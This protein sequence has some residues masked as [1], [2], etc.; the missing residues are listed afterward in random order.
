MILLDNVTYL[1]KQFPKVWEQIRHFQ[2][3]PA[4]SVHLELSKAGDLTFKIQSAGSYQYLHSKYNPI[5]EAEL[6][7]SKYTDIE[8]YKQIFF[9][10]IGLGY[11]I[12]SFVERYPNK[13]YS[14]YEP[15]AEILSVY[16]SQKS[17]EEL[18]FSNIIVEDTHKNI[19]QEIQN[20]V[21]LINEDVLIVTLPSYERI[22]K[23]RFENFSTTLKNAVNGRRSAMHVNNAFEKRWILNS[24]INIQTTLKTPD[25]L[26]MKKDAFNGK[27]AILVAAGPSLEDEINN[28]KKIKEDGSAYIFSVGASIN[29]F[30]K[31]EFE[32]D[33][34]LTYDPTPMNQTVFKSVVD[35]K[36]DTIPLIYGTTVGFE[37]LHSYPGPKLH[38]VTSQDAIADFFFKP[39]DGRIL[40]LV[41]DAPSISVIALQFMLKLGF[42]PI[43]LVGQN[44]AYRNDKVYSSSIEM[45]ESWKITEEQAAFLPKVEDV[46]GQTTVTTESY[47]QMKRSMEHILNSVKGTLFLNTT[48]GGARIEGTTFVHLDEVMEQYLNQSV[49]EKD[50][51]KSEEND[52]Y[53]RDYLTVQSEVLKKHYDNIIVVFQQLVSL[54]Q[55]MDYQ[56]K[57]NAFKNTDKLFGKFD[58]QFRTL[59]KNHYYNYILAPMNRVRSDLLLKQ[60]GR[61]KFE[62]DV[63]IKMQLIINE[64][65]KYMYELQQDMKSLEPVYFGLNQAIAG[66]TVNLVFN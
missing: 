56:I 65:G 9:Y 40:D 27:P 55:E 8:K 54:F 18:R 57:H 53:E 7:I 48:R 3:T 12:K 14:L 35:S 43:I 23:D 37:T 33:A 26:Q 10:G 62:R 6:I 17:I 22:F 19:Q 58:K 2:E 11:H 28:L 44:F 38:M 34:A 31:N 30:I 51:Y 20:F 66:N 16:L 45:Y 49:V 13:S 47:K 29:A 42:N 5:E 52:H 25:I 4:D 1:K 15:S 60:I 46:Y 63:K 24:M 21:D 39:K 50:W 32:P 41:S 59:Q 61:I 64:F 36:I